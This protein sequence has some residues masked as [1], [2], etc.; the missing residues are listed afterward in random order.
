MV[1]R[2]SLTTSYYSIIPRKAL[3]FGEIENNLVG[4][5]LVL[6][7]FYIHFSLRLNSSVWNKLL[8]F[9]YLQNALVEAF[10]HAIFIHSD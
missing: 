4:L 9:H 10:V 2:S 6:H 8:R 5:F 1:S 3:T 7:Y